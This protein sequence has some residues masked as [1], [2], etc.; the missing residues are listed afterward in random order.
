M[1]K[2]FAYVPISWNIRYDHLIP[3]HAFSL[4][5]CGH[6][7]C[8]TCLQSWFKTQPPTVQEGDPVIPVSRKKK[9]CPQCRSIVTQRPVGVFLIR[10]FATHVETMLSMHEGR[11]PVVPQ[12]EDGAGADPWEGVFPAFTNHAADGAIIDDEDGGVRRCPMCTW[13]IF[14]GMCE[15]CGRE[16]DEELDEDDEELFLPPLDYPHEYYDNLLGPLPRP[17]YAG[18]GDYDV[19]EYDTPAEFDV[20]EYEGS[21]I[22]DGEEAE[23][24][25]GWVFYLLYLE[26]VL[27]STC[28][29][30]P[31]NEI[32]EDAQSEHSHSPSQHS[33]YSDHSNRGRRQS[34]EL[35]DAPLYPPDTEVKDWFGSSDSEDYSQKFLPPLRRAQ[36]LVISSDNEDEDIVPVGLLLLSC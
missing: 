29:S 17:F 10:D 31:G 1:Q 19:E 34:I 4:V 14:G 13:E 3:I 16:F 32:Y 8:L 27:I 12:Q 11:P 5:P 21:F 15:G 22:S 9:T 2:P 24:S 25:R 7:S 18:V 30:T 23:G 26:D 33:N 35:A 6:T 20:D 28:S 36:D